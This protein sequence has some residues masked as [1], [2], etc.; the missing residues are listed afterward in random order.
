MIKMQKIYPRCIR[1]HENL[2]FLFYLLILN[3]MKLSYIFTLFIM[4]YSC[5]L[6]T[7]N[8]KKV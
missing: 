8:I 1:A 7:M 5:F 6:N 4:L 2:Q 3:R